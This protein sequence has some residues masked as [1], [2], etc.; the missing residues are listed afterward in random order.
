MIKSLSFWYWFIVVVFQTLELWLKI[1][2]ETGSNDCIFLMRVWCEF[3]WWGWSPGNASERKPS[4]VLFIGSRLSAK[5][6]FFL[7]EYS[8]RVNTLNIASSKSFILEMFKAVL[9]KLN[10]SKK[11]EPRLLC[12]KSECWSIWPLSWKWKIRGSNKIKNWPQ[13]KTRRKSFL[14]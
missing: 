10:F 2:F 6:T 1:V 9:V 11:K 7:E 5:T 4:I 3:Q 8:M 12:F 14:I 13:R